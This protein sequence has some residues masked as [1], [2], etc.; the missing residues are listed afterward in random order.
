MTDRYF[1]L[2][3]I[4]HVSEFA[5]DFSLLLVVV[6]APKPLCFFTSIIVIRI[7]LKGIFSAKFT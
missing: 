5:S 6:L 1:D 3:K 7:I 2:V 4:R